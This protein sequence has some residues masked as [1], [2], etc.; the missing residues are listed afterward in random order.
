LQG[1]SR[2]YFNDAEAGSKTDAQNRK[3][4]TNYQGCGFGLVPDSI[5][6]DPDSESGSM[7]KKMKKKM[8]VSLKPFKTFL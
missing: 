5:S 3:M 6:V 2:V 8:H 1:W 7:G 4:T